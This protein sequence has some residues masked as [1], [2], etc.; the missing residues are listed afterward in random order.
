MH[1]SFTEV[2]VSVLTVVSGTQTQT[3]KHAMLQLPGTHR[4][5]SLEKGADFVYPEIPESQFLA[6]RPI[7]EKRHFANLE[8][9]KIKIYS[10]GLLNKVHLCCA[11]TGLFPLTPIM[12]GP[13]S[14]GIKVKVADNIAQCCSWCMFLYFGEL[15]IFPPHCMN[16]G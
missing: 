16:I 15:T 8:M 3:Y 5:F 6:F 7:K 2:F 10:M 9:S 11:M 13:S 14:I 12:R 4:Y 1:G